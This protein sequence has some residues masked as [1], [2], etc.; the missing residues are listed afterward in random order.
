MNAAAK[1]H[2]R[3]V[4]PACGHAL[5][6]R[7]Q[8]R[9]YPFWS[10]LQPR[11]CGGCGRRLRWQLALHPRLT[12]GAWIFRLGA[13]VVVTSLMTAAVFSASWALLFAALGGAWIA[14]LGGILAVPSSKGQWL[15]VEDLGSPS[16]TL[17]D[18][19]DATR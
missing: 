12:L 15:E 9:L 19:R 3:L 6:R 2:D 5:T 10:G 17:G 16:T 11:P 4:C 7:E 1:S 8:A 18:N 14:L 13:L